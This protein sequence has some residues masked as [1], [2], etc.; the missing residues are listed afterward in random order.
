MCSWCTAGERTT[1]GETCATPD[2][3][4]LFRRTKMV[5]N[6]CDLGQ[7]RAMRS[8]LVNRLYCTDVFL[9]GCPVHTP[10]RFSGIVS[11]KP[12]SPPFLR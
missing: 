10:R 9:S 8:A 2:D 12:E 4:T 5:C 1:K 11:R 7:A 6:P 3:W